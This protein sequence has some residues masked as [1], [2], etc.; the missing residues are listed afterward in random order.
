[1]LSYE[2]LWNL[3]ES[4]GMKKTDLKEV[5]SGN[6]LAKLSSGIAD[7]SVTMAAKAILRNEKP[8]IVAVSTNDGLANACKNIGNL[9]NYKNYY[10][11][12]FNQDSPSE[13]PRSVVADMNLI[14]PTLT[15]ALS[16]KQIQPVISV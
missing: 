11:V 6:T 15:D 13:K 1:M 9:M 4:R 2:K 3:L 16:G 14:C 10:F 12:P 5:I 7:T 8:V